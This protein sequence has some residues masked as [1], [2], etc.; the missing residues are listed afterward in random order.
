[1]ERANPGGHRV[2]R[3]YTPAFFRLYLVLISLLHGYVFPGGF[4]CLK[5]ALP[6]GF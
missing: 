2:T 4:K 3:A 6:Q 1:M 5:V